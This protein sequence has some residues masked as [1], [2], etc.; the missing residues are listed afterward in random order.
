MLNICFVAPYAW[1]ILSGSTTDT[2]VGGSEV[3]MVTMASAMAKRGHRIS[4]LVLDY[5]QA[6]E[7]SIGGVTAYKTHRHDEGI[8][9]LRFLHPRL[10]STWSALRR[11]NASCYLESGAGAMTGITAKFAQL[12]KRSFVYWGASDAD[13]DAQLPLIKYA[14]DRWLYKGGIRYA[15]KVFVQTE[16]Q[17]CAVETV[18][19][20]PSVLLP[21]PF[22]EHQP[23]NITD[24]SAVDTSTNAARNNSGTKV[25]L[26]AARMV[27]LK[28]PERFIQLARL[29]PNHRFVMAGGTTAQLLL[30][31]N[32]QSEESITAADLPPNLDVVGAIP[33]AL[34]DPYFDQAAVIVNTSDIEGLPNTFLQAWSRKKPSLSLFDPGLPIDSPMR[35]LVARDFSYMVVLLS[36]LIANDTYRDGLGA[37]CYEHFKSTHSISAAV[38]TMETH[39][40]ELAI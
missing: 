38:N 4:M 27:A 14:R 21:N 6:D 17:A 1:P 11:C 28:K 5:G 35:A 24:T 8:P 16:R 40:S 31:L 2:T 37:A 15:N 3:K 29:L 7:V 25:I 19:E 23:Q 39:L 32:A 18:F 36:E 10:T 33:F 30:V 9:I 34:I 12:N 20:K 13:F 26:W 22:N